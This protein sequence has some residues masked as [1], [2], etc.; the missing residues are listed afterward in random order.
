MNLF[1]VSVFKI[2]SPKNAPPPVF[3]VELYLEAWLYLNKEKHKCID[4]SNLSN[5]RMT[6]QCQHGRGTSLK[7]PPWVKSYRQ[8]MTA[9]RGRIGF[10]RNELLFSYPVPNGQPIYVYLCVCMCIY[11][12]D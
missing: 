4:Y 3:L 11:M 7:A 8:L 6:T 5:T 1:D 12:Y 10:L 9:Q 2:I